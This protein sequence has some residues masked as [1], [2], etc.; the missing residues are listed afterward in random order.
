MLIAPKIGK[1]IFRDINPKN[2]KEIFEIK[3]DS[4]K[5]EQLLALLQKL[6]I[7]FLNKHYYRK[8]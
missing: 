8:T 4:N 2:R 5:V 6:I 7:E 3:I 1:M